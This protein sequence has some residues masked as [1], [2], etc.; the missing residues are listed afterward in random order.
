MKKIK[1]KING[2]CVEAMVDV[3]SLRGELGLPLHDLFNCGIYHWHTHNKT[4]G[5]NVEDSY[6][7]FLLPAQPQHPP[8][9]QSPKTSLTPTK[10]PS[11]SL[12]CD[13]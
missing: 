7:G 3:N 2:S 5:P 6:H 11:T 1:I 8:L 12:I 10:T 9:T 4:V 13:L